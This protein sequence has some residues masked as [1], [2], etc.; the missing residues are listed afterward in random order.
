[1]PIIIALSFF[2]LSSLLSLFHFPDVI[3]VSELRNISCE[4]SRT[5]TQLCQRPLHRAVAISSALL[6]LF[7]SN[8][9]KID[10]LSN[11]ALYPS[12]SSCS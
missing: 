3:D 6:L 11:D 8:H 1:M 12:Y 5:C 9:F 10:L 7:A 2:T 4:A